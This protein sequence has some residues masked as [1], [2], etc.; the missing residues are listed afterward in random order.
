MWAGEGLLSFSEGREGGEGDRDRDFSAENR[1]AEIIRH[2]ERRHER[3][4]WGERARAKRK[5]GT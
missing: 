3:W 2:T 1:A 4:G 5:G